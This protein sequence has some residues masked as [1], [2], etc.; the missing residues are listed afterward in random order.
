MTTFSDSPC[1]GRDS[2]LALRCFQSRKSE[3]SHTVDLLQRQA[4]TVWSGISAVKLSFCVSR[5]NRLFSAFFRRFHKIV[6]RDYWLRQV[7]LFVRPSIHMEQLGCHWT[8]EN[9]IFEYFSKSASKI[10][11]S[12]KSGKNEVY[13]T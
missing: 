13:F 11:V 1:P 4:A 12:L 5:P 6:E 10:Q 8:A 9:M 2:I 7:G 3:L